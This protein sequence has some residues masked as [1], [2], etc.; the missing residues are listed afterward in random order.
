MATGGDQHPGAE[1]HTMSDAPGV[2]GIH[3]TKTDFSVTQIQGK[4]L[5]RWR[6]NQ[7]VKKL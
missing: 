5:V 4:T 7:E 6:R 1:V 2:H 3:R